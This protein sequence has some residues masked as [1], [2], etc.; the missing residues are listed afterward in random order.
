MDTS[1]QSLDSKL[2]H[3][4]LQDGYP[5][6]HPR[7]GPKGPVV[8][9]YG[10]Q[11]CVFLHQLFIWQFRALLYDLCSI[12]M[13]LK[14]NC[15]DFNSNQLAYPLEKRVEHWVSITKEF[16]TD[17]ALT[18]LSWLLLVQGHLVSM[19]KLVPYVSELFNNSSI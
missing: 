10:S 15:F 11:C 8:N 16:V 2:L 1:D 3:T 5:R 4:N 13:E 6:V 12:Y 19:E 14:F 7:V 17:Q 18:A 9:I